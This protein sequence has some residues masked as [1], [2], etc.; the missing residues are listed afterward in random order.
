MAQFAG[1]VAIVTGAAQGLGEAI[2]DMLVS[3][4]CAVVLFDLDNEKG[5]LV[6]TKLRDRGGQVKFIKVHPLQFD[7]IM[8]R[9]FVG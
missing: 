7:L 4:G 5:E 9:Q 6:A 1:Q 2:A 8:K 3:N